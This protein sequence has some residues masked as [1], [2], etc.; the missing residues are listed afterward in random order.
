MVDRRLV[1]EL[2]SRLSARLVDAIQA[3]SG[4]LTTVAGRR[5]GLREDRTRL[6]LQMGRWMAEEVSS[7]NQSRLQRGDGLLDDDIDRELRR[8][9]Y[10]ETVGTGPLEQFMTDDAVEDSNAP[11]TRSRSGSALNGSNRPT[12]AC[13]HWRIAHSPWA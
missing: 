3:E 6:E 13:P 1:R 8:L 11:F 2:T 5:V 4:T 10:A 9:A 12:R 7:I